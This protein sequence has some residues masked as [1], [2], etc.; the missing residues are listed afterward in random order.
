MA[1]SPAS[2]YSEIQDRTSA[3]LATHRKTMISGMLWSLVSTAGE[4][5]KTRVFKN[6]LAASTSKKTLL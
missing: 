2:T 1:V 5:N 6:A 3:V 4:N